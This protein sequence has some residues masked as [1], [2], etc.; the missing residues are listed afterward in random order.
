VIGPV[1]IGVNDKRKEGDV[2]NVSPATMREM[3]QLL[4]RFEVDM[5]RARESGQIT[6]SFVRSQVASVQQFISYA[7]GD[8]HPGHSSLSRPRTTGY[9]RGL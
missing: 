8:F 1:A 4:K 6:D 2:M 3:E 9:L 7:R 5:R